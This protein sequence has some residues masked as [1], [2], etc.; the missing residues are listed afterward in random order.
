MHSVENWTFQI[1]QLQFLQLIAIVTDWEI[2]RVQIH[3]SK[4]AQYWGKL[5]YA[6][7]K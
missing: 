3:V 1:Y 4:G 7:L 6:F 2:S 5:L